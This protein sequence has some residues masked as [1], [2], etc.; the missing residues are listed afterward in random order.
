MYANGIARVGGI[1]SRRMVGK[2]RL[3]GGHRCRRIVPPGPCSFTQRGEQG[4]SA[5][6]LGRMQVKFGG[7]AE[8]MQTGIK[9][10]SDDFFFAIVRGVHLVEIAE[11]GSERIIAIGMAVE[12]TSGRRARFVPEQVQAEP[13]AGARIRGRERLAV[14][15][16][17]ENRRDQPM[18]VGPEPCAA[19]A[20]VLAGDEFWVSVHHRRRRRGSIV[21]FVAVGSDDDR[22]VVK[23]AKIDRQCAHKVCITE[24]NRDVQTC[25]LIVVAGRL[26]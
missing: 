20:Q 5:Y 4:V 15:A 13:S 7:A 25:G 3:E 9:F 1:R 14:Y 22:M 6:G 23:H 17:I 11:D 10:Q 18:L 12:E 24:R 19:G 21:M 8:N 16:A 2:D 26:C